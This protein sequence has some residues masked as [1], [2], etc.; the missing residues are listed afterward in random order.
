[1]GECMEQNFYDILNIPVDANRMMIRE[2]YLRLKNTY[3][4]ESAAIY[5]VMSP[6]DANA[7]L[8]AI[9]EAFRVLNDDSK[10]LEYDQKIGV[11]GKREGV[12]ANTPQRIARDALYG[13]SS[14]EMGNTNGQIGLSD[15][16]QTLRSTLRVTRTV[17][18]N[19]EDKDVQKKFADILA[20][21][22]LSD[23]HTLV[24]LREAVGVSQDEILDRTKISVEYVRALETNQ[25]ERL[26]QSVYVKGFVR[27]YLKY[28]SVKDPEAIVQAIIKKYEA[29]RTEKNR[30]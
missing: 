28:L 18:K 14:D 30:D 23:G 3:S 26:P 20:N 11:S 2:A 29:W 19:V 1:M 10:R 21:D 12:I 27:N 16:I 9:E 25:Y 8:E 17:A 15:T 22:D 24:K 13:I 6:S 7:Q 5:G 4:Q